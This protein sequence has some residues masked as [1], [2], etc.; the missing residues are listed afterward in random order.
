MGKTDH[1]P[2]PAGGGRAGMDAGADGPAPSPSPTPSPN[3][4]DLLPRRAGGKWFILHTRSRNEK[5]LAADLERMEIPAFLPLV[6]QER[7][8]GDR[9]VIVSVPLFPGY[10]FLHGSIDDAYA[11]DRTR[12]VAQIIQVKDQ[13]RLDWELTNL[14]LALDRQAPLDPYPFLK[15]GTRVEVKSGPFRGLQGLIEGR[16]GDR[17][18]L[19]V[20]MLGQAVTLE[21]HGALLDKID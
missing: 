4:R 12:R 21:L 13:Q 5:A 7:Y 17:L 2:D 6:T 20:E 9:R 3:L 19:E 11:G 15:N 16:N 8:Y 1:P 10:M 18:I 14:A